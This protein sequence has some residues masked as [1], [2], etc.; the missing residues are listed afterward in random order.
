[1][2]PPGA[3][4][5]VAAFDVA[6]IGSGVAGMAAALALSE[7]A[8][9]RVALITKTDSLRGGS[10]AW[11]QGG[12][13]VA[14]APGDT[15]SQHAEDTLRAAAG[16]ADRGVVAVLTS[17]GPKR[18]AALMELGARFDADPSGRLSFGREA[19]HGRPRVL[20]AAGDATGAEIVR[21]MAAAVER[22]PLITTLPGTLA[23]DLV[24]GP[25]DSTD[26]ADHS[27][28]AEH[29]EQ[30]VSGVIVRR[31]GGP[32]QA[33]RSRAV[34]IA[35]GGIGR[36]YARSTN[37]PEVTA[38]GLAM[39]WRAGAWL[40]DV[41]MVQFH[42]TALEVGAD[43]MPLLTEALRGEGALLV[44]AA[45]RR[46]MEGEHPD[47]ELAP[48]DVV[49][50]AIH[51]RTSAGEPVYLDARSSPGDRLP[52]RFP[53][54]FAICRRYGLDP[55]RDLLPVSPA[56]H[57][58]M[59]GIAVDVEGRSSLRGL[60]ACGEAAST[61]AHGANRLA[62]NS[63]LEALVFGN[64]TARAAWRDAGQPRADVQCGPAVVP[65]VEAVAPELSE[66]TGPAAGLPGDVAA[67]A[68]A[69]LRALAW[70]RLGPRRD[71]AGLEAAMSG[72]RRLGL[73]LDPTDVEA[74]N[75][76]IAGRLVAATALRRAE[77]RGAH[78][79][80]D[81]PRPSAD[82]AFR[83]AVRR[84]SDDGIEFGRLEMSLSPDAAARAVAGTV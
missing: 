49:A 51:A 16:L 22:Q 21:S 50:R 5:V 23:I 57:Y 1:M 73:E 75:L 26:H 41:E 17:E 72:I 79:R 59:G 61:G 14:L 69:E 43:P 15:P 80:A 39:A 29:A 74:R 63:L 77:S 47:S 52:E 82:W 30:V 84:A 25:A 53:S 81:H 32:L 27:D 76:S 7:R 40:A 62:S 3:G 65:L 78:Y 54:V 35:S 70:R 37:P 66:A 33:V 8:G 2:A 68:V 28:N 20:H 36:L 11:A 56:A 42:P 55:R 18:V 31:P 46:I 48:R 67:D 60:Y 83:L 58:H 38:D 12:V 10:S 4:Q 64:R 44:D 34:I 24:V 13:A 19:A 9:A 45:G 71:R 6:I